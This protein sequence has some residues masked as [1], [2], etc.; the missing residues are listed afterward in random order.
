MPT[1]LRLPLTPVSVDLRTR[2]DADV[3]EV[4][5]ERFFGVD[6][7]E[8]AERRPDLVETT[9]HL[10]LQP[11]SVAVEG[12]SWL[13][14]RNG[15]IRVEPGTADHSITLTPER[16]ADLVNDQV[17]PVG[18][19]MG[20]EVPFDHSMATILDW[21]L[22]LRSLLDERPV[23]RPGDVELPND[24]G[25][26]F[27][28]DDDP[29]ELRAHLEAT[30]HLHL[31]GVFDPGEMDRVSGEMDA[32]APEY[33]DDGGDH[34]WWATVDGGERRLVRMLGFHTHAPTLAALLA[35][36]RFQ[37]IGRIPGEGRNG[38]WR[39]RGGAEGLFKPLGVQQGIS[40]VPWHKDC[41]PGRHSYDCCS[42]TVGISV[43]GGGPTSG[44]L[45]VIA[46]SNR[47]LVWPSLYDAA[48]AL[49]LPD[50]PLPT[51]TGDV[52][53]HLSCTLHMA[54]PPIDRERRV[55]YTGFALEPLDP[56]A[57]AA[58]LQRLRASRE[59]A[60]RNTSQQA[61]RS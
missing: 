34:S 45:R 41:A 38:P 27:T 22:A 58:G 14:T 25:R 59:A 31:R 9:S 1:T 6:L 17:T 7:P 55:V 11:L 13:L 54:Q 40:D 32:A 30:G 42:L 4:D 2:S 23:H 43:T 16:F 29:A 15:T 24:L 50:V 28:L 3:T 47:A 10:R 26:S 19:F 49:D 61:V 35:D 20:G 52:T 60:P 56:E 8:A 57:A 12:R 46:G 51:E 5:A 48:E 44:Q 53:V 36:D 18:L 37:S 39:W 33:A 21:W